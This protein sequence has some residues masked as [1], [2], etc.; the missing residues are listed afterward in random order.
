MNKSLATNAVSLAVFIFAYFTPTE[1]VWRPYLLDAGLFAL[2]GAF[3]NWIAVYMLFEKIPGFYGS[4]VIPNRFEEFKHSIYTLVMENFFTREN[5]EKYVENSI[6]GHMD[7]EEI[8]DKLYE[9]LIHT[10]KNSSLGPMLAIFGG[11]SK[12]I[13]A[14]WRKPFK[15][16]AI[17]FLK[18]SGVLQ[19][20]NAEDAFLRLK[21]QVEAIVN[22]KLQDLTP[23]KVKELIQGIIQKHLGWLVV[24][25]GVFGA[26]LGA[27]CSFFR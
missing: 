3:T 23:Q 5:F 16:R 27:I 14:A 12:V 7:I 1:Y 18:D 9:E 2:S 19:M 8:L 13:L 4:G 24:W 20:L 6:R 26:I 11:R 25:G 21:P 22:K 10:L 17:L 15:D